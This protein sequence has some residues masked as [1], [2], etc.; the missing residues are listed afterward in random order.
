MQRQITLRNIPEGFNNIIKWVN[1]HKK[2]P[3]DNMVLSLFSLQYSAFS[4]VLRGR[5]GMGNYAHKDEF[6]FTAIEPDD[7]K[8]PHKVVQPDDILKTVKRQ[9]DFFPRASN[10]EILEDLGVSTRQ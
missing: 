10:T 4:E 3:N 8:F 9:I 5:A 7:L 6:R 1:N 2:F